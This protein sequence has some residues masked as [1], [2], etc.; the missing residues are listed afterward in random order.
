MFAV[1]EIAKKQYIVQTG[2]ILDVQKLKDVS[3]ETTFNKVLLVANQGKV[4]IGTPYV[5][6]AKVK[7]DIKGEKKG[8][9]V[10]VY[11]YKRRKKYRRKQG[12]R[13]KYTT[14]KITDIISDITKGSKKEITKKAT[15]KKKTTKKTSTKK[16]TAKKSPTK[17]KTTKKKTTKKSSPKKSS[18]KKS[19]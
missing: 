2:D 15:H 4:K 17:K 14:I 7:A 6:G 9:K 1:V 5:E 3:K 11:K 10:I 13:Q 8:K 12:H 16:A 18:L 19:S